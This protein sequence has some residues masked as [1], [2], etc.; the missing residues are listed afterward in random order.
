[1][2]YNEGHKERYGNVISQ[3]AE[4]ISNNERPVIYGDGTQTRDFTHIG[5]V[6]RAFE[7]S[8]DAESGIYNVGSQ[9]IKSF[10]DVVEEINRNLDKE[11]QAEYI[12]NP[13]PEDVYVEKQNSSYR[14]ISEE[15]GWEPKI[16]FEEGVKGVCEPYRQ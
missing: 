6:I 5:D 4:A 11:V 16:S 2:K 13:I 12:D 7:S 9:N 15:T 1:M 8:L 14:K 3:F 10:N